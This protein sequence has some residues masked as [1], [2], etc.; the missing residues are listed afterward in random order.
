[1]CSCSSPVSL[2]D[3]VWIS[4]LD[5]IEV[6]SLDGVMGELPS[7]SGAALLAHS[8][9]FSAVYKNI[10]SLCPHTLFFPISSSILSFPSPSLCPHIPLSPL[11]SIPPSLSSS[12]HP[13]VPLFSQVR[14]GSTGGPTP[15]GGQHLSGSMEMGRYMVSLQFLILG[16]FSDLHDSVH[17]ESWDYRLRLFRQHQS[18]PHT[19][20]AWNIDPN[21]A[22]L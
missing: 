17:E 19:A 14:K 21:P 13:C 9:C 20:R 7:W 22:F 6:C 2:V 4:V 11:T 5:T 10:S 12:L 1:M 16:W 8:S 18:P 15:Y 3:S